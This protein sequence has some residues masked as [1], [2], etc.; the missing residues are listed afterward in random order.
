MKTTVAEA[1]PGRDVHF[2]ASRCAL[3]LLGPIALTPVASLQ[4]HDGVMH[5]RDLMTVHP[6]QNGLPRTS[7]A[8][9]LAVVR[10]KKRI[11]LPSRKPI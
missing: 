6:E 7:L 2:I 1:L 5:V 8:M 10:E 4:L 9:M 11:A 3:H